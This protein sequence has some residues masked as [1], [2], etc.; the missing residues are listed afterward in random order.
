VIA[1][2]AKPLAL[3]EH[4]GLVLERPVPEVENEA[5]RH[6]VASQKLNE[7][8]VGDDG[9]AVD[10]PKNQKPPNDALGMAHGHGFRLQNA[11]TD[12]TGE[13]EQ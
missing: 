8:A 13:E 9:A 2:K 11:S 10:R 1:Q 7:V 12:V 3:R 6:A 5:A 4:G